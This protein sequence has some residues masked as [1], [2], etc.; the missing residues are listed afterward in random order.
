MNRHSQQTA[1]G[2]ATGV[3]RLPMRAVVQDEYG[4]DPGQ[5]L[6]LEEIDRPEVG[7]EDVLVRVHAASVHIGDWHLMTGL[8]YLL[9]VVGFGFR[10][11]KTR[12]RGMDL[13]GT[14]EAVGDSVTRF[15]AG[16]HVFGTCDGSFADYASAPQDTLAP[17]PTNLTFEEAATIPTSAIAALQA[18]RDAGGIQPGQDVLIVGAS[19]GVGIFAV[20]VA[21]AFG[22]E[23][24]GVCSTGKIDLVRSLGADHIIDYTQEDFTATGPRYDLILDMGGNRSLAQLRRGLRAGGTL[25]S[26]GSEQ[27][28]RLIGGRGWFQAM[29]LSRFNRSLRPLASEPNHADLQVL[30]ELIETGKIRPVIDRTYPLD[31][32]PDAISY[33]KTG[34]ARGKIVIAI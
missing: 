3:T 14:V 16:D 28:N 1:T 9:R 15:S 8:P 24:T 25:V 11:P 27:G 23:V 13:A 12:V 10:A 26:V 7:A 2:E 32:V 17:K 6:R 18:L 19:G 30:A 5:V 31:Q 20:Q 22:A 34:R 33:L 4:E 29:L 21:K